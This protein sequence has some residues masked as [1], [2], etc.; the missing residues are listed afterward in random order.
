MTVTVT[1]QGANEEKV[2]PNNGNRKVKEA[3]HAKSATQKVGA[4]IL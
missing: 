1:P 2:L 4:V 3:K